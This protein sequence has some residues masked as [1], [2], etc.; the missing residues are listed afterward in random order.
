MKTVALFCLLLGVAHI[1]CQHETIQDL[2]DKLE[3]SFFPD[4]ENDNCLGTN[5]SKIFQITQKALVNFEWIKFENNKRHR[6]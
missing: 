4:Y 3:V 2:D 6:F 5:R 1:N